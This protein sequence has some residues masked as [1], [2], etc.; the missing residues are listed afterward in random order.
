ML[1]L[2]FKK[3]FDIEFIQSLYD[4]LQ[5]HDNSL[6]LVLRTKSGR[7]TDDPSKARMGE[8]RNASN[9]PLFGLHPK[10]GVVNLGHAG[11]LQAPL[12]AFLK[13]QGIDQQEVSSDLGIICIVIYVVLIAGGGLIYTTSNNA[14]FLYPYLLACVAFVLSGLTLLSYAY[15]PGQEKWSIPAMI[16]LAIGALPTSPSSLLALPI[17][18]SLGRAKLHRL[19]NQDGEGAETAHT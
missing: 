6:K 14:E 7:K 1:P 13:E 10:E 15:K 17:I 11:E 9:K 16:L 18:K 19:L 12:L 2:S 8:I 5:S 3:S 4:R